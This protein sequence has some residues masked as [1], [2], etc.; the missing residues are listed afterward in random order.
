MTEIATDRPSKGCVPEI[1]LKK[2]K[3]LWKTRRTTKEI[4][5]L[6]Q[7][8]LAYLHTF[9]RRHNLPKRVHIAR[10]ANEKEIDPTPEEI[11]LRAAEVRA[12]W[13]DSDYRKNSCYKPKKVEI[14]N[15]AFNRQT[16]AFF[17]VGPN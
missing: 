15:Y 11:A 3:Q 14:R 13:T 17:S 2:L 7:V 9:A 4:A 6:L 8:S 12:R 5:I 10:K 16:V 1:S